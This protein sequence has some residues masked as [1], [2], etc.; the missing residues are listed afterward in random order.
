MTNTLIRTYS[1]VDAATVVELINTEATQTVGLV[2]AAVNANGGLRLMRYVPS[3]SPSVVAVTPSGRLVGFAYVANREQHVVYEIGVVVHHDHLQSS[4]G[5]ELLDWGERHVHATSRI[6]RPGIR[7]VLQ[8]QLFESEIWA[9]QFFVRAG[10]GHVRTWLHYEA[11]LD[12]QPLAPSIPPGMRLRL[13]DLDHDW[14][15]LGAAM[16][17]AFSDHWGTITMP[18]SEP[19]NSTFWRAADTAFTPDESY[20]NAPGFC[21]L[22]ENSEEVVGGVLCNSRVVERS[23]TGRIGSIFV[24]NR[25]R[26]R[27][28]GRA[29]LLSAFRAFWQDGKARIILDTDAA[30]FTNAPHFYEHMGMQVYRRESVYEKE[31]QSGIEVRQLAA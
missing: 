3:E 18:L 27:G 7:T 25:Y 24:R 14:D 6:A 26:R 21:F 2:R 15:D 17:D 5:T 31:I 30:S 29:L 10:F 16:D 13:I 19:A 11:A 23:D 8:T 20:S 9:Q 1:A 28:V 4:V 12:S 22:L